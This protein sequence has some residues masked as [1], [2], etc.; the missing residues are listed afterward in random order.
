MMQSQQNLREPGFECK[1]SFGVVVETVI[2]SNTLSA[3]REVDETPWATLFRKGIKDSIY[4]LECVHISK[5][6]S[7]TLGYFRFELINNDK[8]DLSSWY[9]RANL[10]GSIGGRILLSSLL[11]T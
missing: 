3:R 6:L 4:T 11:C 1:E 9:Q 7:R 2:F 10:T 8:N 5:I